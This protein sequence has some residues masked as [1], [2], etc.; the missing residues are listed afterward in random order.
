VALV[1]ARGNL[2]SWESFL[3]TS[4]KVSPSTIF[5][6][7]TGIHYRTNENPISDHEHPDD[8]GGIA[9]S[10]PQMTGARRDR[11]RSMMGEG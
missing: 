10:L 5:G 8:L 1:V 6:T 11:Y 3:A 7:E 9:V 4:S 2:L